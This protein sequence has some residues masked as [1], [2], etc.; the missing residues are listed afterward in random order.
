MPY[1]D[2]AGFR[3][4]TSIR[5]FELRV[6][7]ISALVEWWHPEMHTFH[8][9][10]RECTITLEDVAMQLGLPMDGDAVTGLSHIENLAML[11]YDLLG[12]S[13]DDGAAKFTGFKFLW[14]KANFETLSNYVTGREKMFVARDYNCNLY[15]VGDKYAINRRLSLSSSPRPSLSKFPSFGSIETGSSSENNAISEPSAWAPGLDQYSIQCPFH[16]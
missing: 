16:S 4:V 7:L 5:A 15:R 1:L 11:C 6:N 13:P 12:C 3:L 8:F 9:P 10:C 2:A 14:L